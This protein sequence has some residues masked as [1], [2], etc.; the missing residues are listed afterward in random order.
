MFYDEAMDHRLVSVTR[1]NCQVLGR[2]MRRDGER[3]G[4]YGA[5]ERIG[6]IDG[7]PWARNQVQRRLKVR[8]RQ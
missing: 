7:G 1:G 3:I 4:F 2:L 6:N 5:Q 8:N